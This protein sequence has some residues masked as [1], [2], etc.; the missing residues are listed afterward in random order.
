M[1][2]LFVLLVISLASAVGAWRLRPSYGDGAA[3][4]LLALALAVAL[5]WPYAAMLAV[6]GLVAAAMLHRAAPPL[7][8]L[9]LAP[10]A[11][12]SPSPLPAAP[13]APLTIPPSRREPRPSAGVRARFMA[14]MGHELRSPLNS[15]S[16]FAQLL[17]DGSD[18]PLNDAQRENVI[19]V[20]RAAEEL[21]TLL[22]DILDAARIEAGRIRLDRQWIAPVE[23]L[24]LALDRIRQ[25]ET[26]PPSI[27]A[28]V[29]PGLSPL[30]VDRTR[31]G[32]AVF[33]VLRAVVRNGATQHVR[34][35]EMREGDRAV[36]RF[37]LLDRDKLITEA[38]AARAFDPDPAARPEGRSLALGLAL[39]VARELAQ[40]HGGGARA[41]SVDGGTN[42]MLWVPVES[43]EAPPEP[44]RRGPRPRAV[45]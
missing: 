34:V 19:L 31:L 10:A 30:Y 38:D 8:A 20:R 1:T 2:S 15:I 39:S 23:V 45:R 13:P 33:N 40:L 9:P 18:G 41:E 5:P 3:M 14:A 21:L 37:E 25:S 17:E 29:Q 36:V 44:V 6:I 42:W 22:I 28:Q 4:A 43:D 7:A 27:E 11:A 24:T 12:P 16:G 35:R 32:Q 26:E